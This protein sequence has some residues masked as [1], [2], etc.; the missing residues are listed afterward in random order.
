[1]SQWDGGH[2]TGRK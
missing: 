2:F 1:M